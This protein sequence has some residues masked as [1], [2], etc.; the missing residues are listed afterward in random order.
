MKQTDLT[1]RRLTISDLGQATTHRAAAPAPTKPAIPAHSATPAP[2]SKPT[3]AKA[4]KQKQ[5]R[6]PEQ[7]AKAAANIER[8]RSTMRRSAGE[9]RHGTPI[10]PSCALA[11]PLCSILMVHCRLPSVSTTNCAP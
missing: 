5:P 7:V 8:D 1:G 2:S 9:P 4:A 3:K 6:P 10:S 11:S